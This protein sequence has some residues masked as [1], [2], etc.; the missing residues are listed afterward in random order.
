MVKQD[1][2]KYESIENSY[3]F[4]E[5]SKIKEYGL[6]YGEWVVTEKVHGA[7]TTFYLSDIGIKVGRR[8]DF[9]VS[10]EKFNNWETI[11]DEYTPNFRGLFEICGELF[12]ISDETLD[13]RLYGE[14]FGGEYP[15][16]DV[17]RVPNAIRVQ[18]GV[19]YCPDN[20]FYAFDLMVNGEYIAYNLFR[21]I[22][23]KCGFN[24]SKALH[25][26]DFK[27]CLNYKNEYQTTIPSYYGLP[28]IE[29][30]ICEGNV[31]K[32][33]ESKYFPNGKR[34]ILKSKNEKFSEKSK[35]RKVKKSPEEL[36]EDSSTVLDKISCYITE[37]RFD[38]VVSK[39]P[40]VDLDQMGTIIKNFAEDLFAD[41]EKE[42][43]DFN[44]M[45][46]DEIK[47]IRKKA[48]TLIVGFVK[49]RVFARVRG[50]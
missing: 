50:E 31:I 2:H 37:N 47:K 40:E 43:N 26:G 30:N 22:M 11:L 16:P 12:N 49:E 38:A 44:V 45:D 19:F 48:N 20:D 5:I 6:H 25:I 32:P 4:D 3:R 8:T 27:S 13:I 42:N 29:G 10:G 35:E 18:K 46:K 36:S 7:Q 17:E 34:C 9:L 14:I 23:L 1:F 39:L 24:Y 41:F 28:E 33:M 21:E 15:H